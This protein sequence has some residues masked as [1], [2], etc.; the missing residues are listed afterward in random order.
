[1]FRVGP[2]GETSTSVLSRVQIFKSVIFSSFGMPREILLEGVIA[3]AVMN[4]MTV[5]ESCD[6]GVWIF[7]GASLPPLFD[8]F[9]VTIDTE[10]GA[11]TCGGSGIL[12]VMPHFQIRRGQENCQKAL[13]YFLDKGCL[14]FFFFS[15][16]FETGLF[17]SARS[18]AS[19]HLQ[20]NEPFPPLPFFFS[21]TV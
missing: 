20:R 9:F 10:Q 19:F 1:M 18:L 15:K 3:V 6:I 14:V 4:A 8:D 2:S 11:E 12:T 13:T 16:T 7:T 21:N 17:N 5:I